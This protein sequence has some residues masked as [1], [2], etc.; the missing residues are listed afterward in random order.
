MWKINFC[1]LPS[2]S[3]SVIRRSREVYLEEVRFTLCDEVQTF[4]PFHFLRLTVYHIFMDMVSLIIDNQQVW[5]F[6]QIIHFRTFQILSVQH[7]EAVSGRSSGAQRDDVVDDALWGV[8]IW[9]GVI[10]LRKKEMPVGKG[11]QTVT[12][13]LLADAVFLA[14]HIILEESEYFITIRFGDKDV[15]IHIEIIGLHIPFVTSR[16]QP[17]H[18]SVLQSVIDHQSGGNNQKVLGKPSACSVLVSG[19]QHLPEQQGMHHPCFTSGS[20]HFNR[21]LRQCV[22][23]LFKNGE[24]NFRHEIRSYFFIN[25]FHAVHLQHLMEIDNIDDSL[26]LT[27]VEIVFP[28][29]DIRLIKPVSQQVSSYGSHSLHHTSVIHG[30]ISQFGY[31]FRQIQ[32]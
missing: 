29:T 9:D 27:F 14:H 23:L 6:C 20:R 22:F 3:S 5:K 25:V 15:L 24:V 13:S 18:K 17:S 8:I 4:L 31:S 7:I 2:A 1:L 26:S 21:I 28:L 12:G 10:I 16:F 11:N 19:I 30:F 32:R